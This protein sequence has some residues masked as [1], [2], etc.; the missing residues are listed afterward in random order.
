MWKMILVMIMLAASANARYIQGID[1]GSFNVYK[2]DGQAIRQFTTTKAGYI[3]IIVSPLNCTESMMILDAQNKVIAEKGY[4]SSS[5]LNVGLQPGQ[6]YIQI[7]PSSDC[8]I[9]IML[10]Q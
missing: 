8:K 3:N 10:P 4:Y 7:I 1:N 6:Y 2:N 5:K 9:N